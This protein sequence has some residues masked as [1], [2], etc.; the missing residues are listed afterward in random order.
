[1]GTLVVTYTAAVMA[2]KI[3]LIKLEDLFDNSRN[4]LARFFGFGKPY[5]GDGGERKKQGEKCDEKNKKRG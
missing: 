1:M 4:R 3:Q 2:I 5:L